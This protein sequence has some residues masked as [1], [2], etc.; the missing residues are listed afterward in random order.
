MARIEID[1]ALSGSATVDT[2]AGRTIVGVDVT[3]P[4]G[5][6]RRRRR[7]PAVSDH[8]CRHLDIHAA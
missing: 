7:R 2:A 1:E 8:G 5:R 6:A 4:S 3:R